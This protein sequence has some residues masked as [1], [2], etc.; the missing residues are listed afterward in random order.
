M[1]PN[2]EKGPNDRKKVKWEQKKKAH[3]EH[4]LLLAKNFQL[5]PKMVESL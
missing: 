3:L 5:A 4:L 1:P 2:L